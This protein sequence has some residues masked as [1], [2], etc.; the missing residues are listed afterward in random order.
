[1]L[2]YNLKEIKLTDLKNLSRFFLL[3][4][5]IFKIYSQQKLSTKKRDSMS[6]NYSENYLR[7]LLMRLNHKTMIKFKTSWTNN[8]Q[9]QIY[10][11]TVLKPLI[12]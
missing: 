4:T 5:N 12:L 11:T 2:S 9:K 8:F 6:C 10:E 1:M 7:L 3:K